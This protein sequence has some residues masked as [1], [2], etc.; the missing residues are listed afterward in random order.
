[1]FY[2]SRWGAL[3]LPPDEDGPSAPMTQAEAY[4]RLLRQSWFK[5]LMPVGADPAEAAGILRGDEM[6][7][8]AVRDALAVHGLAVDDLIGD[9]DE[10]GLPARRGS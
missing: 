8:D 1:M 5:D 7:R 2:R 3:H 9:A 10:V 4:R 6:R